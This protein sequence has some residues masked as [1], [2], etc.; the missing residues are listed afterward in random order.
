VLFRSIQTTMRFATVLAVLI[1][2]SVEQTWCQLVVNVK[3]K[4]GDIDQE[5]IQANTTADTVHLEFLSK[6]GSLVTQF[7]DYKSVGH[8]SN[9]YVTAQDYSLF[10]F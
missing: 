6:D 8:L 2:I 9:I 10:N 1:A 4:G 5:S 7:I 3:N